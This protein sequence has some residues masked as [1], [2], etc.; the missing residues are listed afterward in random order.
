[1]DEKTLYVAV[2]REVGTNLI[3]EPTRVPPGLNLIK[4]IPYPSGEPAYYIFEKTKKNTNG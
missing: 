2:E 4:A 3:M 1:M